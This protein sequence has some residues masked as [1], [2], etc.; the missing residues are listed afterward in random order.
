MP[1]VKGQSGN[2]AGRRKSEFALAQ[3]CQKYSGEIV[4]NMVKIMRGEAIKRTT[5]RTTDVSGPRWPGGR[6]SC[7]LMCAERNC[8]RLRG[9]LNV[10]TL[11]THRIVRGRALASVTPRPGKKSPHRGILEKLPL[12][13]LGGGLEALKC[14]HD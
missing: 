10:E 4:E 3:E 11:S 9:K 5:K 7:K 2:P 13:A 8:A 1:F 14:V 6:E 12:L